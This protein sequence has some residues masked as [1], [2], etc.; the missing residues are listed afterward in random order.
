MRVS[1]I[2]RPISTKFWQW[3][4]VWK[5]RIVLP[6]I[7]SR[8]SSR[9]GQMPNDSEFGHGMCQNVMIVALGRRSR[10]MRGSSAK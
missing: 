3:K 6:S 4:R 5:P 7:P 9:H 2:D 10:I 8:I 1:R